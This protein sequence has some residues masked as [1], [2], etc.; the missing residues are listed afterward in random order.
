MQ[1]LRLPLDSINLAPYNPR[2]MPGEEM[3]R[4]IASIET[5]GYVDPIIVNTRNKRNIVVGG[6]QRLQALRELDYPE[7]DV[8]EVDLSIEEEMALNLALNKISGKWDYDKLSDV[9]T[10]IK[11]SPLDILATGFSQ[12]EIDALIRSEL[13]ADVAAEPGDV[14]ED[15]YQEWHGGMPE[16][17]CEKQYGVGSVLVHFMTEE[18]RQAFAELVGQPITAKTKFIW[19]PAQEKNF[20]GVCEQDDDE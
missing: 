14:V 13:I 3:D 1:L 7:V 4:L 5:F 19:H 2:I 15:P 12:V 9:L 10:Q 20:A 6:N 8:I 16:Y 18:D 17:N 11:E